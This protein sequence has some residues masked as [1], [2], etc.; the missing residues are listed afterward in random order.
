[1]GVWS[2][3]FLRRALESTT[4]R[5]THSGRVIPPTRLGWNTHRLA[6]P[7]PGGNVR[8]ARRSGRRGRHCGKWESDDAVQADTALRSLSRLRLVCLAGNSLGMTSSYSSLR[9][10]GGLTQQRLGRRLFDRGADLGDKLRAGLL[11]YLKQ[12]PSGLK[13]TPDT[14]E[15]GCLHAAGEVLSRTEC[16]PL[17]RVLLRCVFQA[18]QLL[19]GQDDLD[20]DRPPRRLG[21]EC[22]LRRRSFRLR[23]RQATAWRHAA[24]KFGKNA[25]VRVRKVE[26]PGVTDIRTWGAHEKVTVKRA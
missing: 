8:R 26:Q 14:D 9:L 23:G 24:S 21:E 17:G 15:Q 3:T 7:R 5:T 25:Q 22:L 18:A 10:A 1:V 12:R 16:R 4:E 11:S 20:Y 6:R 2:A 13:R 19:L